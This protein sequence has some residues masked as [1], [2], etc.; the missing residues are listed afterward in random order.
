[1]LKSIA[2]ARRNRSAMFDS[3][4]MIAGPEIVFE[5]FGGDLVVL[6]IST[7]RYFGFNPAAARVWEALMAGVRPATVMSAGLAPASVRSFIEK[8]TACGL[9][10][11]SN[12]VESPLADD[13]RIAL[14]TL[15][16]DPTV[17]VYEDLADLIVADPI[18]DADTSE[19]WPRM[20]KSA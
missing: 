15:K 9:I 20:A 14:S 8:L 13:L 1:M 6:N 11:P 17:D 7:G 12:S 19:G 18:H 2:S 10:V 5:D 4:Y 3:N 16:A